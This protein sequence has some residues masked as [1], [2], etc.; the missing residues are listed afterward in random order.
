MG[1]LNSKIYEDGIN[2]TFLSSSKKYVIALTNA[3]IKAASVNVNNIAAVSAIINGGGIVGNP[4]LSD[5]YLNNVFEYSNKVLT[6]KSL[7]YNYTKDVLSGG[8]GEGET[9]GKYQ[10]AASITASHFAVIEVNAD[11]AGDY[12]EITPFSGAEEK[13]KIPTSTTISSGTVVITGQLS[14]SGVTIQPNNNFL[15]GSV[16]ITFSES[17]S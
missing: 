6:I 17:D 15:F 3:D 5:G 2:N 11:S 14:G 1:Y 12:V 13:I 9:D 16:G 7:S 10:D 8:A 4:S